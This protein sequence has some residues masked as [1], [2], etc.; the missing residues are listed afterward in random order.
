MTMT[1]AAQVAWQMAEAE[2]CSAERFGG[3]IESA[4]HEKK[5][6]VFWGEI[7]TAEVM[8]LALWG[9]GAD[10]KELTHVQTHAAMRTLR[11]RYLAE[12]AEQIAERATELKRGIES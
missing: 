11:R 7:S 10:G 3:W 2:F 8:H 5:L 1:D 12:H 9:Y 6:S 4:S